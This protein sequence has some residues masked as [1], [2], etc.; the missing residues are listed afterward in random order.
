MLARIARNTGEATFSTVKLTES[1]KSNMLSGSDL[2]I[3]SAVVLDRMDIAIHDLFLTRPLVARDFEF[4]SS[5]RRKKKFM[6]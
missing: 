2:R 6:I 3:T 5:A 1:K 4:C